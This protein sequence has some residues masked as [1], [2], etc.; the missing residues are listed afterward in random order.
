[1][2]SSGNEHAI[3]WT[4]PPH[5]VLMCFIQRIYIY[6]IQNNYSNICI[7]ICI[8]CVNI[9]ISTKWT[10]NFILFNSENTDTKTAL[11]SLMT[12]RIYLLHITSGNAKYKHD[13][14]EK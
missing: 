11:R 7:N 9:P 1:M 6:M 13:I 8:L 10:T 2:S 14:I 3:K 12:T 5:Y 4:Q